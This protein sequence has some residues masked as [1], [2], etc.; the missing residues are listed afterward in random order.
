MLM[1]R[2]V[3]VRV[4]VVVRRL[5][6]RRVRVKLVRSVV[7]AELRLVTLILTDRV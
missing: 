4:V 1:R 2:L 3:K 5:V 7:G 6:Q